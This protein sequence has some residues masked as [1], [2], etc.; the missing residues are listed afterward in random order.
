MQRSRYAPCPPEKFA[1]RTTERRR[2]R[3]ILSG[4]PDAG[5]ALVVSGA[6]GAGKTSLLHWIVHEAG[7]DRAVLGWFSP[8]EGLIFSA[9]REVLAGMRGSGFRSAESEPALKALADHLDRYTAP[10]HPVG[11]LA[12]VGEEV[13]GV[14]ADIGAAGFDE[15]VSASLAAFERVGDAARQSGGRLV[16]LLDDLQCA[17]E[18]DFRLALELMRHLP[19]GIVIV[20]AWEG[21]DGDDGRY[22]ALQSAGGEAMPLST[23]DGSGVREVARRRFDIVIAEETAEMLARELCTPF[24]LIALFSLLLIRKRA[25]DRESVAAL[26]PE[27]ADPAARVYIEAEPVWQQRARTLSILNPPVPGVIAACILE[28]ERLS[29]QRISAEL[30]QSPFFRR[31]GANTYDFA[32]PLLRE[33][34]R[35]MVSE[36]E[37]TDLHADAVRCFERFADRLSDRQHALVSL[38][39]HLIGAGEYAKAFALCLELGRRYCEIGAYAAARRLTDQATLAAEKEGDTGSLAA[40]HEQQESIRRARSGAGEMW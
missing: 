25:P 23:L 27:I 28:T 12:R 3:E 39:V 15:V 8:T 2:I 1:G 21:G 16:L 33:C 34:C 14:F 5:R 6:A 30:E 35:A 22:R 9:W 17:S 10:V 37:Q 32:H 38:A 36:R 26:L 20:V 7:R 13:I 24:G 29:L 4:P 19:A 31:A 18:P 40:A 11:M